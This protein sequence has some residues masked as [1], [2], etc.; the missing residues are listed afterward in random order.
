MAAISPALATR[1]HSATAAWSGAPASRAAAR[2]TGTGASIRARGPISRREAAGQGHGQAE[3]GVDRRPAGRDVED[4]PAAA[5]VT[6][7]KIAAEEAQNPPGQSC[8]GGEA[9]QRPEETQDRPLRQDLQEESLPGKAQHPQEG[10]SGPASGDG[11]GLRRED[12]E[13]SGQEGH[14]GQHAEIDTIGAGQVPGPAAFRLRRAEPGVR[15]QEGGD[16]LRQ[17]F[18]PGARGEA[19]VQAGQPAEPVESLL[20]RGDIGHGDALARLYG[21]QTSCDR[22][23]DPLAARQDREGLASRRPERGGEPD[24]V[25]GGEGGA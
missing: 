5:E 15:G 14:H 6:A 11:Q 13:S 17:G 18:G 19:N 16:V 24:R 4:R 8:A 22:Q 3:P 9:C 12:Q 1:P 23:D 10:E 20:D 2:R 25:L 21:G 7:A